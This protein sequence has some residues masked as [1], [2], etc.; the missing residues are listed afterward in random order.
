MG[1]G[2]GV[3]D[4]TGEGLTSGSGGPGKVDDEGGS[5]LGAIGDAESQAVELIP[6]AN[7]IRLHVCRQNVRRGSG[8][9]AT[10]RA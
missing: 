7:D 9:K 4:G 1:G 8:F 6:R 10:S 5:A 3:G 2:T